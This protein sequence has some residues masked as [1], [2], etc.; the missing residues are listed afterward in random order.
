MKHVSKLT[1][2]LMAALVS[3]QNTVQPVGFS[4][5][6]SFVLK[7]K[8]K[9]IVAATVIAAA[10]GVVYGVKCVSTKR[11]EE[12]E[13]IKIQQE[14]KAEDRKRK[15]DQL[16]DVKSIIGEPKQE[17][18]KIETPV[19]QLVEQPSTTNMVAESVCFGLLL[20]Y[21]IW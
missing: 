8:K 16:R 7:H 5:I 19:Q 1:L 15:T 14:K 20:L 9:L 21:L 17:T 4:D 3:S 2:L 13:R 18:P 10:T 11:A 6:S 12:A